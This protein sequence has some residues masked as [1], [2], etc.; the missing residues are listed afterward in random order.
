MAERSEGITARGGDILTA[1]STSHSGPGSSSIRYRSDFNRP[2][3]RCSL[4]PA[5]NRDLSAALFINNKAY[6]LSPFSLGYNINVLC[7]TA[8]SNYIS[9]HRNHKHFDLYF[10]PLLYSL[11]VFLAKCCSIA[12]ETVND[13]LSL[14][15]IC[16]T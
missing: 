15:C 5:L 7:S 3:T 16:R 14:W 13:C 4:L 10:T 2:S 8:E 11:I 6:L 1:G 9:D 12:V